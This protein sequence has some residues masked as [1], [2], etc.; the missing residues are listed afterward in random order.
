MKVA[1]TLL[2]LMLIISTAG[3]QQNRRWL[4]GAWE[5]TGYQI[6]TDTTWPMRLSVRGNRYAI[7]YPSLKCGGTWQLLSVDSWK[8]RFREKI[9]FGLEEC[10]NNGSVVIQ[11]LGHG[12]LAYRFYNRGSRRV[13]ASA[14]LN[15]KPRP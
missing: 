11:R 1:V 14:I 9:S 5:G 2:L 15:R 12:Q 10:V 6:D 8:A 3:A 7:E 13:T 4:S